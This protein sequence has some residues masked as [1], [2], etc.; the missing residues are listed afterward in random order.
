MATKPSLAN[1]HDRFF[2]RIWSRKPVGQDFLR[3]Y[4]PPEVAGRLDLDSLK[5]AKGSFI[6]PRLRGHYSDLL[7]EVRLKDGAPVRVYVLLEHKRDPQRLAAVQLLRYVL[8]IWEQ[9]PDPIPPPVIP[10]LVYHGDRPWPH[11]RSLHEALRPAA[12]LVPYTPQLHFELCDLSGLAEAQI[13]GTVLLRVAMLLMKHIGDKDLGERL[14]GILGLLRELS[15]RRTALG[16]LET[17]LRYL[18]TATDAL[19]EDQV[20]RALRQALPEAEETKMATLAQQWFEQGRAEGHAEGHA[21]GIQTGEQ[22]MLIRLL[23]RR[24]GP[25]PE[26]W[27]ERIAAADAETLLVWSE[28]LLTAR[29]LEEVFAE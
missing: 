3:H 19:S 11:G 5:L 2:R 17:V 16:Y 13:R 20:R 9:A 8:R 15:G 28:R 7:Y 18:A 24:F 21:E 23:E 29:R 26:T 25:L 10:M 4:L 22:K 12:L 1:P 27:R 14:P 6:D